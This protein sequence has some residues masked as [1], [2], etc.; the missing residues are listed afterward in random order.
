MNK[1]IILFSII[2]FAG[3][4]GCQKKTEEPAVLYQ[5]RLASDYAGGLANEWVDLANQMIRQNAI[6]DPQA[7]RAYGYFGLAIYE[8]VVH[9]IPGGKSLSGQVNDLADMPQPNPGQVYDWGIVLCSAMKMVVPAVIDEISAQQRSSI[10]V[11]ASIQE[12]E[13][14]HGLNVSALEAKASRDFGIE[15]GNRIAKRAQNDGREI[16]KNIIPVLPER[17]ATTPQYWDKTTL[18]QL[19]TEPMWST[20]RTFVVDNSAAC[21]ADPPHPFSVEPGSLFYEDAKSVSDNFPLSFF[22]KTIVYHWENGPGRT[23]GAAGHWMNITG[24]MLTRENWHLAKS[25]QAWALVGMTVADAFSVAWYHKYRYNLLRPITYIRENT[26]P[27]WSPAIF[28]PPSPGYI[29]GSA[30]VGGA[31]PIVLKKLFGDVGFV[32]ETQKGSPI[33]TPEG[34]PFILPERNFAS[35]TA[36]GEEQKE[37]MIL[38]GIDFRRAGEQGFL[39]GKCIGST[40]VSRIKLN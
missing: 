2:L 6:P 23:T 30:A 10:E 22:N 9:G 34:G 26:N 25:A 11:L 32:D 27:S 19:P 7:A 16:I 37:A 21:E 12:S 1:R 28:T 4:S 5:T 33:Y 8:S 40:I 17:T 18:N 3:L 29:S 35:F 36:A 13:M 20:I 15:I 31:V 39:S 14:M 24:Q 38:G